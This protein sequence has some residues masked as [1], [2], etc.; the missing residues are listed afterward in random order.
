MGKLFHR[1]LV[2]HKAGFASLIRGT[3]VPSPGA[4]PVKWALPFTIVNP[5]GYCGAGIVHGVFVV[6]AAYAAEVF[7]IVVP[8]NGDGK[9]SHLSELCASVVMIICL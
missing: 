7:P 8:C 3:P 2:P 5:T 9:H 4:T 1:A 6:S